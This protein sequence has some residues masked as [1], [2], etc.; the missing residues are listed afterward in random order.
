MKTKNRIWIC[1]LM[2]TGFLLL[3]ASSSKK[4]GNLPDYASFLN[5]GNI[6]NIE[7]V[8]ICH[9]PCT[10][11]QKTLV[12]PVQALAAHL[13]HGDEIGACATTDVEYIIS[14]SPDPNDPI[15]VDNYLRVFVNGN[16]MVEVMGGGRCCP[17]VLP[18]HFIANS[19]DILRIQ[20][21]DHDVCYSLESLC[22]QKKGGSCLTQ[23]TADIFGP[24]CGS[25]PPQSIF[26]DQT[27]ILP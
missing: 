16:L 15:F 27:F 12:I 25:E 19:G 8:T 14:H 24:N 4:D 11:H 9:N 13:S 5:T 23:L 20:A 3:A 7:M 6:G 2:V 1:T 21:Q 18:I 26:F 10:P 22:L 17:P